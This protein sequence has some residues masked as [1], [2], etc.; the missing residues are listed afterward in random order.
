[1]NAT[2]AKSK[3]AVV[4]KSLLE[5]AHLSNSWVGLDTICEVRDFLLEHYDAFSNV[6]PKTFL[7]TEEALVGKTYRRVVVNMLRRCAKLLNAAIIRQKTQK[8]RNGGNYLV[9][10]ISSFS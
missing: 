3:R 1:M 4:A 10:H 8:W 5:A 7:P 9:L 2:N 6:L